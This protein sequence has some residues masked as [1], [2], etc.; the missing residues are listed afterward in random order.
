MNIKQL[1]K[2][3]NINF[4]FKADTIYKQVPTLGCLWKNSWS[5]LKNSKFKEYAWKDVDSTEV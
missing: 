2:Q 4:N 1:K 3:H 5:K